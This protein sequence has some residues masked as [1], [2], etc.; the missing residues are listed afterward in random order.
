MI[1]LRSLSA[2]VFGSLV[3]G[4]AASLPL[5]S[6]ASAHDYKAGR[7]I[8]D[9]PWTRATPPGARVGGGYLSLRNTGKTSDTLIGG[10]F[11]QSERLEIHTMSLVNDVM[12]MRKLEKGLEIPAGET[13]ELKPGGLHLMFMGLKSKLEADQRIAG[14]LM[15]KKAG[16]VPVEFVV[17]KLGARKPADG[18]VATDHSAH[19]HG[20]DQAV[21][22]ASTSKSA[23]Q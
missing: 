20:G 16:A 2:V 14:Q 8:I 9:H 7:I 10:S 1:G 5:G 18:A 19:N 22:G 11:S 23:S 6:P 21:A 17:E 4:L 3:L 15:F 13:V 12:V